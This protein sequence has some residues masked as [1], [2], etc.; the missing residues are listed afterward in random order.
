MSI[1]S[2][3]HWHHARNGGAERN[4]MR[5]VSQTRGLPRA[6]AGTLTGCVT[7]G[8]QEACRTDE[9]CEASGKLLI[10]CSPSPPEWPSIVPRVRHDS[11]PPQRAPAQVAHAAHGRGHRRRHRGVRLVAHSRRR[12]V[13][14]RERE[15]VRA[16]GDAQCRLARVLDAAQLRAKDPSG[17]RRRVGVMGELVRRHLHQRAQLLRAVRD[18]SGD[19]SRHVS[20]A[21]AAAGAAQGV[22]RRSPGRSPGASSRRSTAGRSATRS[23]CAARSSRARGRSRCAA[24]TTAQRSRPTSR[25]CSSTGRS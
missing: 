9:R 8:P 17:R 3:E 2:R 20:G 16:T 14:G 19:L 15:L 25:R 7:D 10:R 12:L 21:V 1:N 13:C 22:P 18:R 6:R 24:S 23:R 11:D 5:C 4:G